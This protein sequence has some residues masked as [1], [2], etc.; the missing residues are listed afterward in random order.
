M[1]EQCYCSHSCR[2]SA[3]SA[4]VS[5][6][7]HALVALKPTVPSC[8]SGEDSDEENPPVT[9]LPCQ[10]KPPRK[11]KASAMEVSVAEFEKNEYGRTKKYNVQSL[12][13]FDPRPQNM[14][15][16]VV[17]RIPDLLTD[18]KG[19]GLCI[20]LLLDPS[21]CI[22]T[23]EQLV[24]VLTKDE[25][26]KRIEAFKKQLQVSDED[27]RRIEESTRDQSK[28]Q[29]WFE[30]RRFRLTASLFGR[31]KQLKP[32]TA[33]DNLVLTILHGCKEGLRRSVRVW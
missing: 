20:S 1:Y 9:S 29:K 14:K 31:V 7:L 25:L 2:L 19:K 4:H 6:L 8:M 5:A 13:T 33:P 27:V 10:W 23:S 15:G 18:V 11:R 30:A 32:S 21:V 24:V 28:S 17:E 16:T 3:S 12:E 22:E 26:L